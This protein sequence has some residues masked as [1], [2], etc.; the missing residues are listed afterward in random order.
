LGKSHGSG[1]GAVVGLYVD[2]RDRTAVNLPLGTVQ[3]RANFIGAFDIFAV[4]AE[5]FG[6]L[7][8]AR[9]AK[10]A[11]GLVALWVGGPA[12]V[13]ADRHQDRNVVAHRG[14]ELECVEAKRAVAVDDDAL[15]KRAPSM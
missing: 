8:E 6:H 11:A 2:K 3:S 14:V 13:E 10:S 12:A 4:A 5:R 9:V 15:A 7:V 1:P